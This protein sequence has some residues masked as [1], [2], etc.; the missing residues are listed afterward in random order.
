MFFD[1]HLQHSICFQFNT[2]DYN[3]YIISMVKAVFFYQKS[4]CEYF[5]GKKNTAFTN[6][7]I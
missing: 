1:N 5:F 4:G 7:S 3:T 2:H 6:E